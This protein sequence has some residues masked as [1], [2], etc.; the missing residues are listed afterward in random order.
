MK[1]NKQYSW[2]PGPVNIRPD[3]K[4]CNLKNKIFG[5]INAFYNS[6]SDYILSAIFD[7]DTWFIDGK[8]QATIPDKEEFRFVKNIFPYQLP[9]NTNHYIMWYTFTPSDDTINQNIYDEIF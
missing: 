1:Y 9:D 3:Q 4:L 2:I 8:L 6:H 5:D 7:V